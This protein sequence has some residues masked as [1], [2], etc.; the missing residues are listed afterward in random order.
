[1]SR[2]QKIPTA[3]ATPLNKN[4]NLYYFDVPNQYGS[5]DHS[6]SYQEL[7]VLLYKPDG[8]Q[9]SNLKNVVF[10]QDG[11]QYNA[12]SLFRSSNLVESRSGKKYQELNFVNVVSNNLEYWSKGTNNIKADALYSGQGAI[13]SDGSIL[14]VFNNSYSDTNPV[15]R[16]PLSVLYPGDIGVSSSFPQQDDLEYRYTLEP[17][18]SVFMRA[19]NKDLYSHSLLSLGESKSF[20]DASG[21][22]TELKAS[23]TGVVADF[24]VDDNVYI[25]YSDTV[26]G[27]T[28]SQIR[29]LTVVNADV[30]T[31]PGSI[32]FA[33][34]LSVNNIETVTVQKVTITPNPLSCTETSTTNLSL[35]TPYPV[36]K[37][38]YNN[39]NVEIQYL[40]SSGNVSTVLN[41]VGIVTLDG[42]SSNVV[43]FTLQTALPENLVNITVIPLYTNLNDYNWS[44]LSANLVLYKDNSPTV[45]PEKLLMT[46]LSSVN[47]QC[48]AGLDRFSYTFKSPVNTFNTYLMFVDSSNLFGQADEYDYYKYDVNNQDLTMIYIPLNDSVLHKDNLIRTLSN[49]LVYKPKNLAINKDTNLVS[50]FNPQLFPAKIF[51]SQVKGIENYQD[52]MKP[53]NDIK[54]EVFTKTGQQTTAKNVYLFME[55]YIKV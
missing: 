40:D 46:T 24:E 36:N 16:I 5:I 14:S 53:D 7:E 38:L 9:E 34:A 35:V 30:G 11:L 18:Y 43:S 2:I 54:V 19:V 32:E 26:T 17:Q 13:A 45:N 51:H 44:V 42:T 10:G 49:S 21:N 12:S 22:A 20:A 48:T 55:K 27:Q 52:D 15:V 6:S 33:T 47:V 29:K 50:K 4:N 39:T 41:K 1:M 25:T 37:D 8:T 28:L 23:Q 31:T 3:V